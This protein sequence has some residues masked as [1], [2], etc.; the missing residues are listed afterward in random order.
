MSLF[1]IKVVYIIVMKLNNNTHTQY[2]TKDA[3]LNL[4]PIQI[5]KT[6]KSQPWSDGV[7]TLYK[8]Q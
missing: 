7:L 4:Q 8:D 2:K 3:E 5:G 6:K 1:C